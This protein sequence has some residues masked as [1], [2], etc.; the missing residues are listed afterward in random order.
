MSSTPGGTYLAAA[1]WCAGDDDE[2]NG[3]SL[4]MWANG[5]LV[6]TVELLRV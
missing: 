2:L 4:A 3:V 5:V 6:R 1:P